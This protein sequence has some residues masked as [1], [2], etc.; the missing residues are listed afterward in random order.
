MKIAIALVTNR[1][2]KAETVKSL[3]SLSHPTEF[4]LAKEGY[5]IAENRAYAVVQA[6]KIGA[7]HIL[8]VDDDMVFPANT[9]EE[10]LKDD[11]DVVG[12]N[13]QSRKLPL[14]TTVGLL[15]D[16]ELWPHSEI[17]PYYEL[18]E[19]TFEVYSVGMGVCLIKMSVFDQIEEPYFHFETHPNG[20]VLKGEDG[21]F[22]EQ[23]RKAGLKIYCN[24]SLPIG[25]IGDFNYAKY[26]ET[27]AEF[28]P[29]VYES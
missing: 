12:V 26:E 19:G 8:F 27:E 3:M 23:V 10:L 21:W 11:K 9:V 20:K 16:G 24:N 17:P 25:H 1:G 7:T 18:P 2:V 5:T 13:S 28:N 4:I 14:S 22:C 29:I 6:K 15:K